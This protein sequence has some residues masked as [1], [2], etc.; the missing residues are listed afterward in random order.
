MCRWLG[1]LVISFAFATV[2]SAETRIFDLKHRRATEVAEAVRMVLGDDAKV[3]AIDNSLVVNASAADLAGVAEL[4]ARLDRPARMLRVYVAQDQQESSRASSAGG[5]IYVSGGD[6]SVVVGDRPTAHPPAFGGAT[7]IVGGDH[8]MIVGSGSA[9]SRVET[10]RAGQFLT[11]L[12]GSPA[13]ISVGQR[14]P[15][16]ERW[17]VLARRHARIVESVRYE[18]VD[19]G[20][21]VIP[22]LFAGEHAELAIHPFMAFIDARG[23]REIRFSDL[24][25][26]VRVRLGEWF[27]LGGT[28]AGNDEVSREILGI[29]AQ[30]GEGRGNIRVRVELQ[31]E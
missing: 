6:A 17:L 2:A 21:E 15:F 9:G 14:L 5:S 7:V 28:M 3:T 12:E 29:G 25:T 11:S 30:S 23:E 10:H 24:T 1:F 20:F 4:I 13:R 19:T 26:T 8:G 18:S 31:P 16:T 22:T 27:N